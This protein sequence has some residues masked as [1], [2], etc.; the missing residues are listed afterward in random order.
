MRPMER[1]VTFESDGLRLAGSLGVPE[2]LRPGER[3]PALV[4]MHGFGGHRDGPAQRW[5]VKSYGDWGY[6]TLR[7]DFRGCGES[8]GERGRV[9]P[10][11]QVAD[12][13]NAVAWMA[14]QEMVDP[15][16]IGFSG[17]SYGASVAIAA[18]A[19]DQTVAAVIAQ[20]GWA[21]GERWMRW[22]HRGAAAWRAFASRIEAAEAER[23]ATGVSPKLHR[24]DIVPVPEYLRTNID[25]RSIFEFPVETAAETLA[26]DPE[27]FVADVA[28]RPLLLLHSQVD[29]V[30]PASGSVE[31][32]EKAGQ[33]A[34]LMVFSGVDHFMLGEG[35][36]R[37]GDALGDWLAKALPVS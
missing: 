20:G 11:E 17:T 5:C 32:F 18:A 1:D 10:F 26:F 3:R 27:T 29:P 8:A 21:N 33:P 4:I 12:A 23:G 34:D 13:R 36:P 37:V 9:L 6:V 7:F 19:A 35:D 30:V 14:Q 16:R 15:A 22:L 2:D 31:L 25:P 28:P 24:W